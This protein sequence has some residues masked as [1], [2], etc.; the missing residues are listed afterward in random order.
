MLFRDFL[1]CL[2]G[3]VHKN[4]LASTLYD[5]F[6]TDGARGLSRQEFIA[7]WQRGVAEAPY[8]PWSSLRS[9]VSHLCIVAGM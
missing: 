6:A 8:V 1:R 4:D 5:R 7:L 3:Y 9:A 2:A